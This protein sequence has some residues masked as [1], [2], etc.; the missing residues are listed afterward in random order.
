MVLFIQPNVS[1]G[2]QGERMCSFY[3][4]DVVGTRVMTGRRSSNRQPRTRSYIVQQDEKLETISNDYARC[5][6]EFDSRDRLLLQPE[7]NWSCT[8]S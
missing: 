4:K 5:A 6:R 8:S 3:H 1:Y 7:G 2:F